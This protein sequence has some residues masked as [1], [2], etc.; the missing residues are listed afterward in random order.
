MVYDITKSIAPQFI[1]YI[2][3]RDFARDPETDT[4]EDLAPEGLLFMEAANSPI[5]KPLLV[6]ANEISRSTTIYAIN[7]AT[8]SAGGE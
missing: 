7:F 2:N 5:N 3:N 8:K 6:V 1:Q 4:A